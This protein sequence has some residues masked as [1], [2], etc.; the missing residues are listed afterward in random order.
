MSATDKL[1]GEE[2]NLFSKY[3]LSALLSDINVNSPSSMYSSGYSSIH[4]SPSEHMGSNSDK[5]Y[6]QEWIQVRCRELADKEV[7]LNAR[8]AYIKKKEHEYF[9]APCSSDKVTPTAICIG[10]SIVL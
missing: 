8:E 5:P 9:M 10:M 4:E 6:R 2:Q 3:N 7:E 1:M